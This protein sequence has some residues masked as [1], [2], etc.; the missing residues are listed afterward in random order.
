MVV[1]AKTKIFDGKKYYYH[2]AYDDIF[3]A[4]IAKTLLKGTGFFVREVKF[5]Y[6]GKRTRKPLYVLYKRRK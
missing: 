2:D 5:Y 1:W 4:D 3:R 6:Q